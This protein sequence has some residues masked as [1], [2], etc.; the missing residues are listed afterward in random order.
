MKLPDKGFTL[1]ELLL[2]AAILALA[3]SSILTLF[4]NCL[5]LN[6]SNSNISIATAHGQYTLESVKNTNFTT[7]KSQTWDRT[8]ISAKGLTPLDSE[9]I[10]IDVT[11]EEV[12]DII[13]TVSW[14]DRGIRNRSLILE[15]L[16]TE[17]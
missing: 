15:T 9:S 16:L 17:P 1:A 6:T 5:F 7:I 14:K 11:G 2:A 3:L 10:V 12:L 13:V 4:I 8:A